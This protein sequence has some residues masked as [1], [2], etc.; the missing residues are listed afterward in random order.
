MALG[1]HRRTSCTELK[2][3]ACWRLAWQVPRSLLARAHEVI[4]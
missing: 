1:I 3:T 4:E 2:Q